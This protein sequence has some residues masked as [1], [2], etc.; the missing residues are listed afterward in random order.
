MTNKNGL[1]NGAISIPGKKRTC[2]RPPSPTRLTDALADQLTYVSLASLA[3]P[4]R[5][6]QVLE[7]TL[8]ANG[9]KSAL[10][11]LSGQADAELWLIDL[12]YRRQSKLRINGDQPGACTRQLLARSWPS[13]RSEVC[14]I[15]TNVAP[16]EL[17]W[18]PK[19]GPCFRVG[20]VPFYNCIALMQWRPEPMR[21]PKVAAA[22]NVLFD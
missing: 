17:L 18:R 15:A 11:V 20:T 7:I 13:R 2:P 3:Y 8:P 6:G 12:P 21:D 19:W 9:E 1:G 4:T 5:E 14:I 22:T 10:Y 16:R